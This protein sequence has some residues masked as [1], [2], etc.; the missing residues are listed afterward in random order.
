VARDVAARGVVGGVG[1]A[2]GCRGGDGAG[3]AGRRGGGG[4]GGVSCRGEGGAGEA[5]SP[6]RTSCS[7]GSHG[8][9][10]DRGWR[11][12]PRHPW[13]SAESWPSGA[14]EQGRRDGEPG[15]GGRARRRSRTPRS[16]RL[17][18]DARAPPR[19]PPAS[20]AGGP[21]DPASCQRSSA[22]VEG[23]GGAAAAPQ[24]VEEAKKPAQ[25]RERGR[26]RRWMR[27][28]REAE[29]ARWAEEGGV[30]GG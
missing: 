27:E 21:L 25:G 16:F 23:E 26:Q 7:S 5:R 19:L 3:A 24:K 22:A 11:P 15:C 8:F 17:L 12:P 2:S 14:C 6:A 10:R 13:I 30:G 1:A 28:E 29:G 9:A 18:A 4:A 20:S